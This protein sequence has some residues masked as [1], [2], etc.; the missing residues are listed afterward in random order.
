VQFRFRSIEAMS[1]R[2]AG[3]F[4]GWKPE[5]ELHQTSPGIWTIVLPL[6]TGVHDYAFIVDGSEWVTDPYA[7]AVDDGFG[8]VNSRLAI[9]ATD[10]RQS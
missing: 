5:Y 6:A 7:P 8:G 2:L 3:S 10:R 9:V 1:V 4:T